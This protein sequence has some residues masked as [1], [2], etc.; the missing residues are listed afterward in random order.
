MKNIGRWVGV[1]AVALVVA[2]GFSAAAPPK[3]APTTTFRTE[4]AAGP[5]KISPKA[6]LAPEAFKKA[7]KIKANP[8]SEDSKPFW[9]NFKNDG[10]MDRATNCG[11]TRYSSVLWGI[12]P[13]VSWEDTC[14]AT[15]ADVAGTHFEAP[16]RCVNVGPGINEWGEF[17]VSDQTCNC[18]DVPVCHWDPCA[19]GE[20]C[21]TFDQNGVCIAWSCIPGQNCSEKQRVCCQ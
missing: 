17:Y 14:A 7:I 20:Q 12:P 1:V 15:A 3:K 9:G 6:K 19:G 2:E 21:D 16:N 8:R 5:A 10:C 4:K 13:G 11:F 18:I